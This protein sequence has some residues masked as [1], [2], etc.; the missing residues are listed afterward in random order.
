MSAFINRQEV[1]ERGG[2]VCVHTFVYVCAVYCW[3][4][5][6]TH[7]LHA[8]T[9]PPLEYFI[10]A[11]IELSFIWRYRTASLPVFENGAFIRHWWHSSLDLVPNQWLFNVFSMIHEIGSIYEDLWKVSHLHLWEER[12]W[13]FQAPLSALISFF[14]FSRGVY[15]GFKMWIIITPPKDI[16]SLRLDFREILNVATSS[17]HLCPFSIGVPYDG[18]NSSSSACFSWNYLNL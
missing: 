18:I 10:A 1:I 12:V 13:V 17:Y 5:F 4:H 3:P 7:N 9:L 14:H 2:L 8:P 11:F 15:L 16:F 6:I